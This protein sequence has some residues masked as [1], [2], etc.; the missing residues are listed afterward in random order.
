[1]SLSSTPV[2]TLPKGGDALA[3]S[4]DFCRR[5]TRRRARNF[6]YGMMLTPQPR[7]AAMYAVYAWMR[8]ADDL[9]DDLTAPT[10]D[11]EAGQRRL[12]AFRRRTHDV[13]AR[14]DDAADDPAAVAPMWPAVGQ[15]MRQFSVPVQYLD[16]MI[17]GQ[18]IDLT[19]TRY[20]A[21]G[22]LFDYCYKVAGTVGLVCISVWGY[23]GGDKTR[24]LAALRGR[25]LQLTNILRDVVED[26]RRGRVYL[27]AESLAPFGFDAETFR[28]FAIDPQ[29]RRMSA[30][31]ALMRHHLA[32]A[33]GYYQEC[34]GLEANLT[35]T[36]R[37][38][39]WA[40]MKIYERLLASM[41][42]RPQRVLGGR[43]RLGSWRK[44]VIAGRAMVKRLGA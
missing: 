7:R 4:F 38:T 27:P 5:V 43:V 26:A 3:A 31:T 20:A 37:P 24:R 35:R 34:K 22:E 41:E 13:I 33:R 16:D 30:F 28:Q 44:L 15:T 42:R 29:P 8:A 40:M 1:M 23:E 18:L 39:A 2:A 17:D 21:V 36:C 12:E 6:Y 11:A 25:A 32:L 9:A 19:R 10:A 14:H